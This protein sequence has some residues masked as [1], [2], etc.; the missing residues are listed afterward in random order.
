MYGEDME[1]F[2]A[3]VARPAVR[4]V[5]FFVAMSLATLLVAFV[6][7]FPTFWHPLAQGSFHAHPIVYI[8]G[9]LFFCWTILLVVQS[10]LA[11]KR[12][13]R[14]HRTLGTIG[15]AYATLTAVSGLLVMLNAAA[16]ANAAGQLSAAASVLIFPALGM[17]VFAWL[18]TLG[19][20]NVRRTEFHQR[21]ILLATISALD[22]PVARWIL[23]DGHQSAG[24]GEGM[25]ASLVYEVMIALLAIHDYRRLG[26]VH[27]ATLIGGGII[28]LG[29]ILRVLLGNSAWWAGAVSTLPSLY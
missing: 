8:H 20:T 6:G 7:F 27:P 29:Q 28:I 21:Y 15:I 12:S 9:G 16:G 25:A 13:L 2:T 24:F 4:E 18:V 17:P 26:R 14:L 5:R 22:A 19:F 11:A 1:N 10:D 3:E 23:F